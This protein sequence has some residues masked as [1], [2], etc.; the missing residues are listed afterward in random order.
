MG[1]V[2]VNFSYKKEVAVIVIVLVYV[3]LVI[4]L[5]V[6]AIVTV[7]AAVI[8]IGGIGSKWKSSLCKHKESFLKI[9]INV[10]R[11]ILRYEYYKEISKNNHLILNTWC[12]NNENLVPKCIN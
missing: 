5:I 9:V 1:K 10:L 11:P 3:M 7:N 2:W 12:I 4:L 8:I 6:M